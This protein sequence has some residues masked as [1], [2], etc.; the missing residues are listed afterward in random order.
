MENRWRSFEP[1]A[2]LLYLAAKTGQ[3]M[4]ARP[5][6]RY[7]VI[8]WLMFEMSDIGPMFGQSGHFLRAAPEQIPYAIARYTNESRRL[9]KVM[10]EGGLGESA[11]PG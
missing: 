1:E 10:E 9:L 6:A 3:L 8:R 2:I 11:V 7:K 5:R 4:P